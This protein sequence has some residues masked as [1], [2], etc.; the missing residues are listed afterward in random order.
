MV[1]KAGLAVS[2]QMIAYEAKAISDQTT[3]RQ[4][5]INIHGL[6]NAFQYPNYPSAI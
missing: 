2:K 6:V 3:I 4:T 1:K 5:H